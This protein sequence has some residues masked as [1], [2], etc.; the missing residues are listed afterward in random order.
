MDE[1]A[2]ITQLLCAWRDGDDQALAQLTPLVYDEL[3]RL[4]RNA[5]KGEHPGH[6]LQ[7]TALAHEAYAK[8]I[9]ADV[10]WQDRAHFFALSARMMRRILITHAKG[11]NAAK[12]GGDE[13]PITLQE[14]LVAGTSSGL[15]LLELDQTLSRLAEFDERKAQ[16]IEL[17]IF[18]GLTFDEMS[19]VTGLSTSTIH[20]DLR[21]AKAWLKNEL[22]TE[23]AS[24]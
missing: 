4:A 2:Q 11:R 9:K 8:L 15:R 23:T 7:P 16:L 6:T 18:G 20:R 19:E 10:P 12:R 5:F 1:E 22:Q 13:R 3:K 14:E 17:Q 21:L 24:D